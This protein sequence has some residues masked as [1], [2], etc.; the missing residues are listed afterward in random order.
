M[1][2]SLA[3]LA[4][5]ALSASPPAAPA[6]PGAASAPAA[7][8][9]APVEHPKVMLHTSMGDITIELFPEKAP[10]TV[11][12]FLQYT[13]DKFYNGT[14]FHRVIDGFMIQ[15]GGFTQDLKPKATRPSIPNE[16]KN[17]LS[18]LTGTV[19]MARTSDPN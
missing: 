6:K 8:P 5:F 4:A 9:A 1:L 14:V 19:A 18:N 10:K 13:R 15:G 16:A 17:G 12:N 3:F 2:Q 7:T 11:D